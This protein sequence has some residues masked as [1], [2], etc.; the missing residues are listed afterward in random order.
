M[1]KHGRER[2]TARHRAGRGRAVTICDVYS[3]GLELW[4]AHEWRISGGAER[5][6][7]GSVRYPVG[8]G[9]HRFSGGG[10]G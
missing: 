7:L 6:M 5:V 8:C 9:D 1:P 4:F 3:S 10:G 2:I